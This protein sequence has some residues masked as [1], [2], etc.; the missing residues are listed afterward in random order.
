MS[1]MRTRQCHRSRHRKMQY[2]KKQL[3][4]IGFKGPKEENAYKL[5]GD[6]KKWLVGAARH[7]GAKMPLFN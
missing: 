4:R 2:A 3:R 1:R 7:T 5:L 6:K